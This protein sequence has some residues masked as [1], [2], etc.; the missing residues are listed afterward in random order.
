VKRLLL[1][2]LLPALLP[3]QNISCSLA[4]TVQ[5]STGAVVSNAKVTLTGQENGFVR[6]V[7]TNNEGFFSYPDLTPA[8]F[9]IVIEAPGFK[10]Y[11]ETGILINADERRSL[12]QVKLQ[13]G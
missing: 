6:T 12:G 4:G 11:R 8:T 5:D 2:L 7:T 9:T 13:V 1:A 3:A 10:I